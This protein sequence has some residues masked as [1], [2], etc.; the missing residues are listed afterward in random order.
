MIVDALG[1]LLPAELQFLIS[2]RGAH[3]TT[4]A[5]MTLVLSAAFI[6]VLIARHRPQSSGIAEH[7]VRTL[8]AWLADKAG[9]GDPVLVTLC[10]NS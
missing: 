5:F 2:D 7:F 6:H 8:K 3:F 1:L 10:S 4:N 9:P